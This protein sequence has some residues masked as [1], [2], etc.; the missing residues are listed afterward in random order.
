[1]TPEAWKQWDEKSE[2]LFQVGTPAVTQPLL[3][4]AAASESRGQKVES[5]ALLYISLFRQDDNTA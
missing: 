1:M 2:K 5:P 3:Q 4:G